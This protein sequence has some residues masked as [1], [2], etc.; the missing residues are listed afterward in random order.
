MCK[1]L[2]Y[3]TCFVWVLAALPAVTHAQVNNLALNPSFE[4][5]DDLIQDDPA[6]F[7][8]ATWNPAEGAGSTVSIDETDF[9]DGKRSLRIDAIGTSDWHFIV[10][11][12]PVP[13]VVGTSYTTSFWAKAQE[14][15]S[16]GAQYKATDNT[17]SWGFASFQ[18]TTEWAEYTFT[19]PA[20]NAELKLELFC[21]GSQ[22]PVWVDFFNI[23]EG[24]YVA[25]IEPGGVSS[26]GQASDPSTADEATDV[27][28][29]VV[30]GW[31]PGEFAAPTNGHKVYFSENFNDVND[32]IGGVTQDANSYIPPQRPDFSTTYYWRVDEV[33]SPPDSTVFEGDVW[34]FTTEPFA[35]AVENIT[36]TASS[37]HL[38]DTGPENTINGS[39]LDA[40]DLHSI[41]PADMWLSGDEP[42]GAWIEYELDKVYKLHEMWVWNHNGMLE[43]VLGF[44]LKDVTIEYS[45][46]GT[47]YTTL[48]TTHE[49]ARAPGTD[50][51][52][53]N[54]TI[55]LSGVTAKYVRL[56]TNS[57]WGA[58]LLD[59]YGLSEVR[60]LYIPVRARGPQ[61]ESGTT[62]VAVD[63]TLGFRA[64]READTHDVYLSTDEQAVIDGN[65]P[66]S[67]VTETNYG[68]LSLDLGTTYYWKINEV[69]EAE[70]P[71]TWQGDIWN[72]TTHEFFVVD[73]FEDY[74]DY[75][76]DEIWST[77]VDGYG[78]PTNGA[79]VGYPNPDWNQDE[80]YVETT[81]VHG[82][83]QS[84]PFFYSNTGGAT[85]SEGERTFAVPQDWTKASV[86]TLTLYFYG[87]AG[88]T[89]Q[90]YVKVNGSKVVYDGDAGNLARA[91]WQA[92]NIE[93]ASFG[94]NLQSVTTLGIGID[95]NGASGTLYFDDIR[96][97]PYSRQFITPVDPGSDGLVAFYALENDVLDGSGNGNDG[98]IVGDPVFVEGPAGYGM[99]MEFDGDDYV[100]TGNTEDLATWTIACWAKSPAAPSGDSASG[101]IH[102][103]NNYQFNWNHGNE[104]FRASVSINAGG[105]HAASFGTLEADTW[106]HLAG[107]YDGEELKS[108]Q[109]G[110]LI[111]TNDAPSGPPDAETGTLKLA[112]HA[113]AVQYFTGT[114]DEVTI[115][116]SVLSDAEIA[117]LAG[118]TEPFDKPF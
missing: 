46:N 71:T 13:V 20:E 2:I 11:N 93:L 74:N 40:N 97:Y 82:G 100:D 50:G 57:N 55:D 78:V 64:G 92:W 113:T 45:T 101:P 1:R 30:L 99:A 110:I 3:L 58:G 111:T 54:T 27:P 52:E 68:P 79:T 73:G 29:D 69:N 47:D 76:P 9:I 61:P 109:D 63:V 88:N 31:T 25:G 48:G 98:T 116:N 105:W 49:F 42:N 84:M 114:V 85:Y 80:H 23:Y 24:E 36:A 34:S 95:G 112:R 10:L 96:R 4:E 87:T 62:D 22:V 91:G 56:T 89:G 103:E 7:K 14:P 102:R 66:V 104:T 81:I 72:F 70:T 6:W 117:W 21:A 115:Y 43:S 5:E 26:P 83:D 41:E 19:A 107:T 75:P 15:R 12:L 35:Y 51:Y 18:L 17:V 60:F 53:H 16:F 90:L 65:V 118:W 32:G 106:Y 37:T 108:Y 67:T 39:G 77:W 38:A 33:N 86:Q 59:Q 94:T 44:G 28:R 8:W